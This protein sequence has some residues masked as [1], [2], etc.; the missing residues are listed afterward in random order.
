MKKITFILLFIFIATAFF[1]VGCG[2]DDVKTPEDIK[3]TVAWL[4]AKSALPVFP[5]GDKPIYMFFNALWC[6]ISK[7]MR[8]EIFA[9]PEI[10]EYMNRNF[11][12]ISVIPDSIDHVE[13]LGKEMTGK[14]L[15]TNF[16][17]SGYPFHFFSTP[18]G[19]LIGAREGFIDLEEFKQMLIY[20]SKGYYKK[21]DFETFVKTRDAEVDTVYGEF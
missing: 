12:C 4:D 15:L 6:P 14:E 8:E 18:Q 10:I 17:V 7:E 2:G 11:T 9:R 21:F 16:K 3:T 13:F 5:F 1:S 20:F 19:K